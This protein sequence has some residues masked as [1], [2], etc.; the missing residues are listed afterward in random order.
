[1]HMLNF[2]EKPSKNIYSFTNIYTLGLK[3]KILLQ[4]LFS[5]YE[6]GY[7]CTYPKNDTGASFSRD[8]VLNAVELH[9]FTKQRT[10]I[11][12]VIYE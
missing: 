11:I 6:I 10:T 5:C 4:I 1:M 7:V 12:V 9:P 3:I 8:F 2:N